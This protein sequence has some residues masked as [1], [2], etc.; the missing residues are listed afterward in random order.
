M[1]GV[2]VLPP[3][4]NTPTPNM[5]TP[6][7][8][9]VVCAP[10]CGMCHEWASPRP[11]GAFESGDI[12]TAVV[13]HSALIWQ[14]HKRRGAY[15]VSGPSADGV[16]GNDEALASRVCEL[17]NKKNKTFHINIKSLRNENEMMRL[18]LRASAY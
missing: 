5:P 14:P 7:I 6:N 18:L 9:R 15:F 17:I 12:I 11:L 16:F 1:L 4:P 8:P 3:T 2:S 10:A 13:E